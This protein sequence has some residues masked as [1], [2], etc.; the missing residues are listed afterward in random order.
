MEREKISTDDRCSSLSKEISKLKEETTNE[1]RKYNQLEA[2]NR[3]IQRDV[4]NY[5]ARI[6]DLEEDLQKNR[7]EM[8][9][10][11]RRGT[12]NKSRPLDDEE[13]GEED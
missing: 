4:D 5:K 11:K 8:L 1:A 7:E 6:R 2:N 10:Q 9:R 12:Y 3:L 13:V